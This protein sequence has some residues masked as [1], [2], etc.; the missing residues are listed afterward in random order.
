MVSVPFAK[1]WRLP[2]YPD[3]TEVFRLLRQPSG[4]HEAALMAVAALGL[5][6]VPNGVVLTAT[7]VASR[8]VSSPDC[9]AWLVKAPRS[10]KSNFHFIGAGE[11]RDISDSK[12]A[13]YFSCGAE[14]S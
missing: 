1:K 2:D 14:N 7:A 6:K 5:W 12:Y 9:G 8:V 10:V 3:W 4:S 11:F 13:R